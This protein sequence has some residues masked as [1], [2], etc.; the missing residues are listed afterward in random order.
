[1]KRLNIFIFIYIFGLLGCL[2]GPKVTLYGL[3]IIRPESAEVAFSSVF[4]GDEGNIQYIHIPEYCDS[5]IRCWGSWSNYG[6][7]NF[8]IENNSKKPIEMNYLIDK[9]ELITKNKSIYKLEIIFPRDVNAMER[10]HRPLNPGDS[11]SFRL[12][13]YG[14]KISDVD[15]ITSLINYG[16]T[17]LI[18]RPLIEKS[19]D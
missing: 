1:M 10:Y 11:K 12:S 17:F 4:E 14:E 8:T 18:L 16:K 15:Y 13:G 19:T 9:Y 5:N 7:I 6:S 3:S 2:A